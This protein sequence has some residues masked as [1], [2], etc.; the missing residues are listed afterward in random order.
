MK[1]TLATS[2]VLLLLI[3]SLLLVDGGTLAKRKIK[4]GYCGTIISPFS[5]IERFGYVEL[6][7]IPQPGCTAISKKK[8]KK[9]K[10]NED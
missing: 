2:C 5:L 7:I 1:T 4:K 9:K 6:C 10:K 8:K 3:F